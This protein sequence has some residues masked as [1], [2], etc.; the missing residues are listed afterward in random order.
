MNLEES[1]RFY[2]DNSASTYSPMYRDIAAAIADD[3]DL[4]SIVADSPVDASHPGVF[5]GVVRFLLLGGI[6]HPLGDIYAGRLDSSGVVDAFRSFVDQYRPEI[7]A[8]MQTRRVQTNE[9]ARCSVL[10]AGLAEVAERHT[11]PLALIDVGASGGLNLAIDRLQV[12]YGHFVSGPSSPVTVVCESLSDGPPRR[13]TPNI[14][15]RAGIDRN[16]LDLSDPD[17]VRW[18]QACIW[19]EHSD[20]QQRL[21]AAIELFNA[22]PVPIVAGDAIADLP[23]LIADAPADHH[24]TLMSSWVVFYFSPEDR[25]AYEQVLADAGRPLSWVSAEHPS[26]VRSLV[27]KTEPMTGEGDFS[28]LAL[29]DY[30]GDGTHPDREFLAWCHNHGAWIDWQF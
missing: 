25:L 9:V 22:E 12:D 11:E 7:M 3:P 21:L 6:D 10:L 13:P 15:W 20:R 16:P 26:V 1:F 18:L 28:A 8:L 2:S 5:L 4:L 30:A 14:G 17:E 23:A 24:L 19:P 29:L 27:G